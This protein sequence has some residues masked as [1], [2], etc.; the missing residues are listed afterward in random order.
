M[1]MANVGRQTRP[2]TSP[3]QANDVD[4]TLTGGRGL[5]QDEPLLFDLGGWDK[6][7]VDLPGTEEDGAEL[8]D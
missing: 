1:S 6:T 7:G 2:E 8:G 5:L 3:S 4:A